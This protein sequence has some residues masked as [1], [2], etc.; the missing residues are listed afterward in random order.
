MSKASKETLKSS[1]SVKSSKKD[2]NKNVDLTADDR[3]VPFAIIFVLFLIVM[4]VSLT[5]AYFSIN[6]TKQTND[7][8]TD[9]ETA[10]LDIDFET[11]QYISNDNAMLINDND[12]Y[13]DADKTIFSVTRSEYN[14][15]EKVYY[16]LSLVDVEISPNLDSPYLK[17]RLYDTHDITSDTEPLNFGTFE[18]IE[19]N[20][21]SLYDV[22]IPLADGVKDNFVLLIWLSNDENK[23]QIE[24]LNGTLSAK[25][26]VTAVNVEN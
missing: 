11:S 8:T 2:K 16:T 17:W 4:A 23:N 7:P 18:N 6:Y 14:T 24:L 5:Y 20:T 22:K 13:N 25:V 21:I 19:N 12:A 9:V 10:L 3:A 15:V 1:I 26:Q